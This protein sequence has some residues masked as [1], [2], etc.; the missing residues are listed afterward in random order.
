MKQFLL[1]EPDPGRGERHVVARIVSGGQTGV[2]RAALDVAIELGIKHGGYA[3]AGRRAEDGPIADRYDLIELPSPEYDARTERNVLE[4]DATLIVSIGPLTG[5]SAT[6][7]R[8]ARLHD[9][10]VLH[11]DLT[12]VT[13]DD[14]P[15]KIRLW[16]DELRPIVLNIAGPRESTT[17]G[18]YDVVL[19]LLRDAFA[20]PASPPKEW[21]RV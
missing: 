17:P 19:P 6:T 14:A 1:N 16:L 2:D 9:R 5:G 4:S 13:V 11:I 10:G 8:M 3:P 18:I 15:A 21:H 12:R 7:Q 20:P